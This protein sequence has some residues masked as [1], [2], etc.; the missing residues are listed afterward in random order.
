MAEARAVVANVIAAQPAFSSETVDAAM[1]YALEGGKGLR[2][3]LVLEGAR[4][5][6]VEAASAGLAAAGIECFHAYSLLHDVLPC[7]VADE[8]RR[9][10]TTVLR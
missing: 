2:A 5:L 7:L 4:L 9:G 6:G 10:L 1:R 8:L 3:F